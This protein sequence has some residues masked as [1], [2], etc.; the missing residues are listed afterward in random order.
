MIGYRIAAP[1][2]LEPP[3]SQSRGPRVPW[4]AR[5]AGAIGAWFIYRLIAMFGRTHAWRDVPWLAGP[6]GDDVIGDAPYREGAAK[7]GLT[8]ERDAKDG[9]LIP[10]FEALRDDHF[11]PD[12][13]HPLVREFY[14]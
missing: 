1:A 3:P 8:I 6:V 10:D 12:R 9:G 2:P 13:L 5:I 14:E 7:E 11:D 4:L